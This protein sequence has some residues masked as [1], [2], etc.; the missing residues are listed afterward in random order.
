MQFKKNQVWK[1][2]QLLSNLQL[3]IVMLL[4]IASISIIGTVIEQNKTLE[5]Y[6]QNY[7]INESKLIN[8][9]SWKIILILQLNKIF[10]AWWFIALLLFFASTI[11][12]CTISRQLPILKISQQIKFYKKLRSILYD[13]KKSNNL[14]S[15][16]V[17]L[18]KNYY[19]VFQ[20][21]NQLYAYK[22]ILGR[23]APIVVHISMLFILVGASIGFL[24]GFIA[25]EMVPKGELFHIQ[26]M[27][28]TGIASKIPKNISFRLKDFWIKY[29][30]D[31]S[32][33]QFYS[34]IEVYQGSNKALEKLISVNEPLHYQGITIYQTDWNINGVR[35]SINNNVVQI[36]MQVTITN[37]NQK[38]WL[39]NISD[40]KSKF[41]LTINQL[42]NLVN[43]YNENGNLLKIVKLNE[44]F[45]LNDVEYQ[46]LEVLTSSG[47]QIKTDPGI[48]IVYFGF[49]C[50]MSSSLLSYLSFDQV[51]LSKIRKTISLNGNTNRSI[52]EF[53]NTMSNLIKDSINY[54][55]NSVI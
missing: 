48:P 41:I 22:G 46:I 16:I 21:K 6:Q 7:P 31:N 24:Q 39:N 23:L 9:F 25:Q 35:I 1:I 28:T 51:W 33:N 11:I 34:K 2:V 13:D 54:K 29:N 44:I 45:F 14:N 52:L 12:A 32:I 55:K 36:P 15:Y 10:E 18:S 26:N 40:G 47:L 17:S 43:L 4:I 5:F 37:K 19:F 20:N 50:L 30:A 42:D 38:I 3:S 49:L 27:V 8:I 53:E